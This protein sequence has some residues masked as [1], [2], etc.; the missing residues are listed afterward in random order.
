MPDRG[1]PDGLF[2]IR[3][4]SSFLQGSRVIDRMLGLAFDGGGALPAAD[5]EFAHVRSSLQGSPSFANRRG[6]LV[7][8]ER[9]ALILAG[10]ELVGGVVAALVANAG[11][12][13][14]A[15]AWLGAAGFVAAWMIMV[16]VLHL[17]GYATL[18][19]GVRE[20]L[21]LGVLGGAL[22]LGLLLL[23]GFA[24]QWLGAISRLWFFAWAGGVFATI[25]TARLFWTLILDRALSRGQCVEL[26]VVLAGSD[27]AAAALAETLR[28][29]SDG[30]IGILFSAAIPD[31]PEAI[32]AIERAIRDDLCRRVIVGGFEQVPVS[33][34]AMVDRL[35]L[36]AVDV[37]VIPNLDGLGGSV[38]RVDRIGSLPAIDL[39]SRPLTVTQA[40]LKRAEDLLLASIALLMLAPLLALIA[41]GV[42]L[43]SCGPVLFRQP[44]E[45]YNGRVF[46]LL[47]F[48]TMYADRSD[49]AATRQTSRGD[50]RV[51]K[52]GAMLRRTS[53]DE[54]PQLVNVLRGEMSIVGPRPH[55]LGMTM[56]GTQ[57]GELLASYGSRHRLPP[58]IT[59][60][61]QV[62]NCRGEINT[63]EKLRRRVYFDCE[64]I[65]RWSLALDVWIIIK[66]VWLV[67]NDRDAY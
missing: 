21:R 19:S 29:E 32:V 67:F 50:P 49:R 1:R 25:G 3:L 28:R 34:R 31:S 42:K 57:L 52:F 17:Y 39:A 43:D 10:T 4:K 15:Y 30:R 9:W 16:R 44:R 54:L 55:A 47:K 22:A 23:I 40:V 7:P 65:N 58:G 53:L 35:A 13:P 5:I 60:W 2:R 61:A 24:T 62:R 33:V 8:I 37:T 59:G 18:L 27:G 14:A 46:E 26:A 51:T 56:L 6:D 41:I 45:G 11:I 64:Y 63:E 48:R 38:G 66:T 20:N 12:A 36:V